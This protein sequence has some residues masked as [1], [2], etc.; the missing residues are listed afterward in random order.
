MH[1]HMLT[2]CTGVKSI[3]QMK[4]KRWSKQAFECRKH[5]NRNQLKLNQG[6]AGTCSYVRCDMEENFMIKRCA[7]KFY[8]ISLLY[9]GINKMCAVK[10]RGK[11]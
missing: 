8:V 5:R 6:I 2:L 3:L 11:L 4:M 10:I 7:G 1:V 9:T